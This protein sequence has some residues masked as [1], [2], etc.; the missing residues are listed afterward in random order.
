MDDDTKL[1]EVD[2]GF[3]TPNVK[4][5]FEKTSCFESQ[6]SQIISAIVSE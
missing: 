5:V 1:K 3:V 4:I 6:L 2:T